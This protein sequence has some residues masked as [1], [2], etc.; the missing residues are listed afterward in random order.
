[1]EDLGNGQYAIGYKDDQIAA[2][3]KNGSVKLEVWLEGNN[4]A[5]A[6]ASVSVS[7]KVV[8]FKNK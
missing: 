3:A 4:T 2:K 6:N 1:V 5:K 7:V 8:A